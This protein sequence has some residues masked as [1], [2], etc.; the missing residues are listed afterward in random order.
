MSKFG[1]GFIVGAALA[2]AAAAAAYKNQ[3]K[4]KEKVDEAL[5]NENVVHAINTVKET[6][7][8]VVATV[9][10]KVEE[11]GINET[12]ETVKTKLG[13]AVEATKAKANELGLD[14]TLETVKTKVGEAANATK[15][16]AQDAVDA[17]KDSANK[18]SRQV[19]KAVS[20]LTT[21]YQNV[22]SEVIDATIEGVKTVLEDLDGDTECSLSQALSFDNEDTLNE[23]L[24]VADAAG[25]KV[26]KSEELSVKISKNIENSVDTVVA[27][28]LSNINNYGV[29]YKG[30]KIE[31][32]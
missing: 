26:E 23:F 11:L 19:N 17:A 4:I 29:N 27:D 13:E 14:E 31:K 7:T 25:Y 30:W 6:K 28:I 12:L 5:E 16:M 20:G 10:G 2:A 18:I 3:D 32:I 24:A 15:E 8:K 22:D 9:E 1:K 21:K